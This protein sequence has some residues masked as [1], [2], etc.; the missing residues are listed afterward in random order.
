MLQKLITRHVR[1]YLISTILTWFVLTPCAKA[2]DYPNRQ[3]KI[4][5]PTAAGGGFDLT[6]RVLAERLSP[7]L[8][9]GVVIENRTGAGTLVGT[10]AAAKST[11][12]GY[13]L[14]MGAFSN[15]GLNSGLYAKLPYDPIKDFVPISI[16]VAYPFVLVAR[17]D[18][19]QASL[20]DVL[21]AARIGPATISYASGG[22]ATG[23]HIAM[24][25]LEQLNGV[26]FNHVP[27]KGA[28]PAYQDMIGGRIDLMFDNVSTALPQI[29]GKAVRALT[30]SSATRLRQL[31]EVPTIEQAGGGKLEF[32]SWFGLFA[33]SATPEA[34][35]SKLTSSVSDVVSLPELG[36]I[37]ARSGGRVVGLSG[38]PAR[39][40]VESE[41]LRWSR[42]I[43]Q[44]GITG[45]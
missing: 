14:L 16:V 37:F 29:E 6:A 7:R 1:P 32:E 35:I 2:Q 9:Q 4:I 22:R 8:G 12:D 24:A 43:K 38:K 23:Q 17:N 19:P 18:L 28:Q 42:I 36:A 41:V 13:T 44:T 34:A 26:T 15:F 20:R 30:V 21:A 45:Q 11:P 25:A 33:P 3:I 27:Y 10:E 5:V 31:P 40:M 39:D